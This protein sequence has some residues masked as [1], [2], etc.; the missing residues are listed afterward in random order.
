MIEQRR[1]L[2]D[3]FVKVIFFLNR[4]VL[5]AVLT[6]VIKPLPVAYANGPI[7]FSENFDTFTGDGFD[8]NPVAGQLDSDLWRVT[9]FSDGDGTFGGIHTTGDWAR[10]PSSGGV[11]TGGV[12]AFD[13][14]SGNIILGA[15]SGGTDFTPGDIVL[16]LQNNTGSTVT[17]LNVSYD[18]WYLNDRP[19]A[20][21]LNLSYSFDDV[22]YTP[23]PALD[24]TTPEPADALPVWQ[25]ASRSTTLTG[26]NIA[27]GA[28][29]YLKWTGDDVSGAGARDEYGL[30]NVQVAVPV[31]DSSPTVATA[32]PTSGALNVPVNA[33][34]TLNFSEDVTVTNPWFTL[35]CT[36]SGGHTVAVSGGPQTYTLNPD[37][38]FS[39]S[40]TC[41][42]TILAAQVADQDGSPDNMAA[43][44]VFSFTTVAPPA[45]WI[46][47]EIHADPD[48]LAGDANG[49]GLINTD[50]DEFLEIINNTGTSADISGWTL[51][52]NIGVRHTFP[53]GTELPNR[54]AVVVFGGGT[55]TGLFGDA[56]VQSTGSLG[57]NNGGEAPS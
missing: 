17:Q 40:E 44:Y 9:G 33:N 41:T 57:L 26:L 47:N 2:R 13:V 31:G 32:T 15:Q 36:V 3:C 49:D 5:L 45:T 29:F 8:T 53:A 56:L 55:P 14:G 39:N 25:S 48:A 18:L 19:R 42:A 46:I 12:Y 28:S 20:N 10:G 11:G 27:S 1:S 23:I 22:T 34:I 21:L 4:L 35:N 37:T 6:L 16:R 30:D 52:D 38:D 50:D 24:F 43:D 54:C 7:P 51:S